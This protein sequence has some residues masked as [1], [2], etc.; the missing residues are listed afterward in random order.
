M[1]AR[2]R[3]KY[4][5]DALAILPDD[6]PNTYKEGVYWYHKG[7]VDKTYFVHLMI[8][9][10]CPHNVDGNCDTYNDR[11]VACEKLGIGSDECNNIRHWDGLPLIK[12]EDIK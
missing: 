2:H 10:L 4:F 12:L 11:P 1:P 7:Y 3:E 9:G 6:V 8:I 5:P